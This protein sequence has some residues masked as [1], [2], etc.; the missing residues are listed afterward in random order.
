[1]RL[2]SAER[3]ENC[4]IPSVDWGDYF[5]HFMLM[6]SFTFSRDDSDLLQAFGKHLLQS[7]LCALFAAVRSKY[8]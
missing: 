7:I 4:T 3:A 6:F 8:R 5:V 2:K 1:M